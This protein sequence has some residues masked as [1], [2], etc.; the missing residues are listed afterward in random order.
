MDVIAKHFAKLLIRNN[1]KWLLYEDMSKNLHDAEYKL[2]L[3]LYNQHNN[4][5]DRLWITQEINATYESQC[6][7]SNEMYKLDQE[8]KEI[9][10]EYRD[11]RLKYNQSQQSSN[12]INAR[13]GTEKMHKQT[14][15]QPYE[16]ASSAEVY[17][18]NKTLQHVNI[19]N[20]M[21]NK[22]CLRN[23]KLTN[24]NTMKPVVDQK[25]NQDDNQSNTKQLKHITE[26]IATHRPAKNQQYG[27]ENEFINTNSESIDRNLNHIISK[28]NAI[29]S[30]SN[31]KP[32]SEIVI[33]SKDIITENKNKPMT[34]N[35][36]QIESIQKLESIESKKHAE[37]INIDK[38]NEEQQNE[39]TRKKQETLIYVEK[40]KSMNKPQIKQT[41]E[42]NHIESRNRENLKTNQS[43]DTMDERP[44][45]TENAWNAFHRAE[46]PVTELREM[47]ADPLIKHSHTTHLIAK[48]CASIDNNGNIVTHQRARYKSDH[49]IT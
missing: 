5:Q 31:K 48:L 24:N 34:Q 1:Q 41:L 11:H 12:Q 44:Q 25:L 16:N 30:V 20:N 17:T 38:K 9:K 7:I 22:D 26:V 37:R 14:N 4:T 39:T 32:E 27:N 2:Q 21:S 40:E 18:I 35:I 19:K 6:Q 45:A 36:D 23:N 43:R 10:Q 46:G 15:H 13:Y 33:C 28:I 42:I 47:R 29:Y 49:R 8:S 3:L